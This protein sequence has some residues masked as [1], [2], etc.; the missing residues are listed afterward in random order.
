MQFTTVSACMIS[1][2]VAS[3]NAATLPK[4]QSDALIAQFR[5][6]SAAGCF[7]RNEGF[8][9]IDQSQANN[10]TSFA[11]YDADT[12]FVSIELQDVLTGGENCALYL[13]SDT[14]CTANS[15]VAALDVCQDAAVI[16]PGASLP[17]WNSY[18]Y[19][20]PTSS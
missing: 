16:Q 3:A 19:S 11:P 14:G 17:T 9:T 2:A 20:C 10:C 18:Y 12:P 1:L 15:T 5:V 7:D 8:F 4:R 13:Y 6:Y